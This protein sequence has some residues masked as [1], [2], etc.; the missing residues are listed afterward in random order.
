VA[1][2]VKLK[3]LLNSMTQMNVD[4]G[5]QRNVRCFSS[6][7]TSWEWENENGEW[8]LYPDA[9]QRLLGACSE[10]GVSERVIEAA[11]RQYKVDF[12][13]KTQTNTETGVGRNIRST[14]GKIQYISLYSTAF[15]CL[16]AMCCLCFYGDLA[17]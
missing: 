1:P 10:C 14:P 13:A 17:L 6:K 3:V 11:G 15:I 4:S 16:L 7:P 9:L 2:S 12:I 5:W 8:K